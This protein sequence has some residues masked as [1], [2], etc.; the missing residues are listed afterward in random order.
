MTP[1]MDPARLNDILATV[2]SHPNAPKTLV[3]AVCATVAAQMRA[4][5][6]LDPLPSRRPKDRVENEQEHGQENQKM[7]EG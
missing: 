7:I 1:L 4:W 3:N 6:G 5:R 2:L